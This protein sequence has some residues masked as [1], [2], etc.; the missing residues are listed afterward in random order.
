MTDKKG[1][2]EFEHG[3]CLHEYDFGV[4]QTGISNTET[5]I[6]DIKL[7]QKAILAKINGL[8]DR[9]KAQDKS[10]GRLWKFIYVALGSAGAAV[11]TAIK[12]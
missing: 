12:F 3:V 10:I 5:D 4:I 6:A 1:S 7:D 9:L 2:I 8:P 11:V